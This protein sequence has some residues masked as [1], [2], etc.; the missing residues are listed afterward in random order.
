MGNEY[1]IGSDGELYHWGWK[2]KDHKYISREKKGGKWVYTYPDDKKKDSKG[3]NTGSG[4]IDSKKTSAVTTAAKN[5]VKKPLSNEYMIETAYN[6]KKNGFGGSNNS[7]PNR[8]DSGRNALGKANSGSGSN[9][10]IKNVKNTGF[11]TLADDMKDVPKAVIRN[12]VR[13]VT[14]N[15][16]S[17][18]YMIE[19]AYNSKK[20]EFKSPDSQG[21]IKPAEKTGWEK[22]VDK[23][24]DVVFDIQFEAEYAYDQAKDWVSDTVSNIEDNTIGKIRDWY[25]ADDR[26]RYKYAEQELERSTRNYQ[27]ALSLMKDKRE[28]VK[29]YPHSDI[30]KNSAE[31]SK[32]RLER[33]YTEWKEKKE[34]FE[35]ARERYEDTPCAKVDEWFD[36]LEDW[37]EELKR[38]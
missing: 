22:F 12:A 13:E 5:I 15:P 11:K 23:M 37:W 9:D 34:E 36:S 7:T 17:N 30:F 29:N 3:A 25:G 24:E 18:E 10:S 26:N 6:S 16:L 4:A 19:N 31:D 21:L 35:R 14:K 38:K 8:V 2:K 27:S 1:F 32:R 20:N 28:F 33:S